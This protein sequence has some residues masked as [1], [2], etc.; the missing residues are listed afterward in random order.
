MSD[1]QG[2]GTSAAGHNAVCLA[3]R[4][5][6]DPEQRVLPSG[7]RV[8]LFRVVVPRGQPRGRQRVDALECAAWSRRVQRSVARWRD[9]DLVAVEGALRRR[10]FRAVGGAQSRVEVEVTRARIIRRATSA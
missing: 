9:G 7:D 10:F 4:V 1:V 6:G 3:G 8:W 5:S 2:S